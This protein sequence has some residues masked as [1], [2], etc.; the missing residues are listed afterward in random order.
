MIAVSQMLAESAGSCLSRTKVI[1]INT[2]ASTPMTTFA[3]SASAT[4]RPSHGSPQSSVE[5]PTVAPMISPSTRPDATSRVATR[6]TLLASSR[7]RARERT[8]TVSVWIPAL[9]P[10]PPTIGR[11]AATMATRVSVSSNRATTHAAPSR[12]TTFTSNHG[13]R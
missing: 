8:T 2:P 11:K 10:R 4:T 6:K 13:R 12:A 3:T 7:P 1:G 5:A 9:P